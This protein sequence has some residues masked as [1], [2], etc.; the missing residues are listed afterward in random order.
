MDSQ[1][2]LAGIK[3]FTFSKKKTTFYYISSIL[4]L[5]SLYNSAEKNQCSTGMFS[6]CNITQ[7]W[8]TAPVLKQV[9]SLG[10]ICIFWKVMVLS[11]GLPYRTFWQRITNN[12]SH[13]EHSMTVSHKV[14]AFKKCHFKDW[15]GNLLVLL[16]MLQSGM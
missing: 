14:T 4:H 5:Y 10:L 7:A 3:V 11:S 16:E 12:L 8:V 15:N 13:M 9:L 2:V 6:F 1:M